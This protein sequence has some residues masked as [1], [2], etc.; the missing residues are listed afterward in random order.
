MVSLSANAS[1]SNAPALAFSA[2]AQNRCGQI[3]ETR[4]ALGRLRD[5]LKDRRLAQDRQLQPL[6]READ[7][8]DLDLAFPGDPFAP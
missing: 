2:M 8:I 7:E 6:L 3:P 1:G 4:V 5:L